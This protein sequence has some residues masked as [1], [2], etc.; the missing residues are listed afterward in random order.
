MRLPA[1]RGL[2]MRIAAAAIVVAVIAVGIVAAGTLI[3]GAQ[4]FVNLM[5]AD[6]HPASTSQAMILAGVVMPLW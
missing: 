6:G 4:S 2:G 1:P 5:T 3:L